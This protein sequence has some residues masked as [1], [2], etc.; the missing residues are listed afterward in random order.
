MLLLKDTH[1]P[2]GNPSVWLGAVIRCEEAGRLHVDIHG[3]PSPS[4]PSSGSLV[5]HPATTFPN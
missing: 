3:K 4:E 1:G 2:V 5:K